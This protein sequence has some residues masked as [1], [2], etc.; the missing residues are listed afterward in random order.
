MRFESLLVLATMV[1]TAFGAILDQSKLKIPTARA[2]LTDIR[3]FSRVSRCRDGKPT[4]LA[5]SP[6][7]GLWET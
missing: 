4:R 6:S 2:V 1:A 7:L 3:T 5:G